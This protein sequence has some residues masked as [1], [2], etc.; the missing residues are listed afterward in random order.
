MLKSFG[1]VLEAESLKIWSSEQ[2][3]RNPEPSEGGGGKRQYASYQIVNAICFLFIL[4]GNHKLQFYI[5][6]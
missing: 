1:I 5:L 4:E 3:R 6:L 2:R